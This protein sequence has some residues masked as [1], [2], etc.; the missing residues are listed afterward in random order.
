MVLV[1]L[2]IVAHLQFEQLGLDVLNGVQPHVPHLLH[3]LHKL[4]VAHRRSGA[5]ERVGE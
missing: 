2:V 1:V 3:E 5:L 4:H